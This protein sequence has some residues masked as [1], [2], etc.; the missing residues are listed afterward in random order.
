MSVQFRASGA[1]APEPRRSIAERAVSAHPDAAEAWFLKATAA[2]DASAR[3]A[4]LERAAAVDR[5]HP[6]VALLAAEDA[7]GRGTPA[8]ALEQV[9]FALR[10][11]ALTPRMLGLYAAALEATGRCSQAATVAQNASAMFG[12]NC[13]LRHSETDE[14][15]GC[16]EYVQSKV[17]SPPCRTAQRAARTRAQ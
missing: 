10:R 3:H 9:R 7:L 4:A 17:G 6:G 12:A 11:S 16:A 14:R 13:S 15:L 5:G 1:D 2:P 8:L